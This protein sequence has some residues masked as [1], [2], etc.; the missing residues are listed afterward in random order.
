[1]D[2]HTPLDIPVQKIPDISPMQLIALRKKAHA[3][4]PLVRIGKTKLCQTLFQEIIK[5]LRVHRL[6][7]IKLL[8][9]F[10]DDIPMTKRELGVELALKTSSILI[11]VVGNT[12][13]LWRK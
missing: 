11:S 1:M 12:V 8:K 6:V 2:E 5:Q 13:V 7:K 9:N 4:Q 10:I 3:I